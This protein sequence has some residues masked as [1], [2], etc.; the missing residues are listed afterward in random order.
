MM[1]TKILLPAL[2]CLAT[3]AGC[4]G[5]DP[6][7]DCDAGTDADGAEWADSD[8]DTISNGDEG[9]AFGRDT[10]GDTIPDYLDDDS[11]GDGWS[12]ED[13]AGDDDLRTEPRDSD[14]DG[15]PDYRDTDSDGNGIDDR[16][17]TDGDTDG[18]GTLDVFDLD[19]DGDGCIDP[20]EGSADGTDTDGDGTPDY[21]DEDSDGDGISDED[22]GCDDDCDDDLI[23]NRL[24]TDSDDSGVDD[25]VEGDG[26]TD[27]E[28]TTGFDEVPDYCDADNDG[29]GIKDR[30]EA[31]T[32][33]TD[34]NV[35]DTDGDGDFDYLEIVLGTDPLDDG[36]TVPGD[37]IIVGPG[38]T[39]VTY[40][41]TT[42]IPRVD[43]AILAGTG[44]D[45]AD[46]LA[47]IEA[48]LMTELGSLALPDLEVSVS[49]FEDFGSLGYGPAEA[50][51]VQVHL[52]ST[53]EVDAI[54]GGLSALSA[55]G[56]L[57]ESTITERAGAVEAVYQLLTGEGFGDGLIP[58][59][60]CTTGPLEPVRFGLACLRE[61]AYTIMAIVSDRLAWNTPGC[62]PGDTSCEYDEDDFPP[63]TVPHTY[64]VTGGRAY[65]LGVRVLGVAAEPDA[66]LSDDPGS[67]LD[68]LA[69]DTSTVDGTGA[70]M[71]IDLG[72]DSSAT[73]SR[74]AGAV[75]ALVGSSPFDAVAEIVD[76]PDES[77]QQEIS[78]NAH[79]LI[80][81][82]ASCSPASGSWGSCSFLGSRVEGVGAAVDV[83]VQIV[84]S[85][86]SVHKG[87]DVLAFEVRF[88]VEERMV[89]DTRRGYLIV[90]QVWFPEL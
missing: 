14:F 7:T 23:P 61:D 87:V 84:F 1:P 62:P 36:S 69:L 86:P 57:M 66:T 27:A 72:T 16:D 51:P 52:H 68:R 15:T 70:S 8:G 74:M 75:N 18:D 4:Y 65:D 39:P 44:G 2:L 3:T 26:N 41:V 49:S 38:I 56:T 60:S 79:A 29:D 76:L 9:Y 37:L 25:A 35:W 63:L 43:L 58:N 21:M 28:S 31:E 48:H 10:D 19:D 73:A 45:L 89:I 53:S 71:T 47:D 12:D 54:T 77:P 82:P 81:L 64:A 40:T 24:D 90:P 85:V 33:G 67:W 50:I 42:Q 17:E 80:A 32:Y 30:E 34:P 88:A 6:C 13:E 78:V 83:T 59:A 20:R 46:E 5:N 55:R 22:E 11:D